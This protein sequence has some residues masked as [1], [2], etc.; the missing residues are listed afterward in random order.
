MT[1]VFAIVHVVPSCFQFITSELIILSFNYQKVRL[2]DFILHYS[3]SDL[4]FD[5][6]LNFIF[7][8]RL[9][10]LHYD[11]TA[12]CVIAQCLNNTTW[13]THLNDILCLKLTKFDWSQI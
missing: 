12:K 9:T 13:E 2:A 4:E 1:V 5:Q 6:I 8:N 3:I 7:S 11:N 10:N